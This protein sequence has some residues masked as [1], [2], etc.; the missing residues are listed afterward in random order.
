M[1]WGACGMTTDTHLGI[2]PRTLALVLIT[3][4]REASDL[5]PT[6]FGSLLSHGSS[7]DSFV[8]LKAVLPMEIR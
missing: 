4:A 1:L 7:H 3:V 5:L 8:S 6:A 2:Q